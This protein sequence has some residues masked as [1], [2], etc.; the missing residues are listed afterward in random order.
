MLLAALLDEV[1]SSDVEPDPPP[2]P[3]VSPVELVPDEDDASVVLVESCPEVDGDSVVVKGDVSLS[4]G[5]QPQ[6][7]AKARSSGRDRG[8]MSRA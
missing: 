4:R 8:R 1:D 5:V 2:L 3:L 6:A 7:S